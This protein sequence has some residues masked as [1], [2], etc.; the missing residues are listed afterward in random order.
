MSYME[1]LLLSKT[2]CFGFVGVRGVSKSWSAQYVLEV[3]SD[4]GW[5]PLL[6]DPKG[7]DEA[8]HLPAQDLQAEKLKTFGLEPKGFKTRYLTFRFPLGMENV[9]MN[10]ELE[11][12]SV[13]MLSF[14]HFRTLSGF[15]S[16]GEGREL[17]DAY[18]LAGGESASIED[19]ITALLRRK[20]PKASPRVLSLLISLFSDKSPFEPENLLEIVSKY[21]FTVIST[22]YF[23]PSARDLALFSLNIV[24]DNLASYL[25]QNIV[26][27][28]MIIHVRELREVAP[29]EGAMGSQWHLRE[30]IGNLVTFL[31]QA[32]TAVTR[33][34]FEVQN[35]KSIPKIILENSYGLFVHPFNFKDASQ[36]KELEKFFPIPESVIRS[37]AALE[38]VSHGTWIYISKDGHAEYV[39]IPPP[40]SLRIPEPADLDDATRLAGIYSQ[41]S[42]RRSLEKEAE[43][44]RMRYKYWI[45][46]AKVLRMEGK[47][48]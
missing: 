27:M 28:R 46:R 29:R 33:F 37:T 45:A 19:I 14:G 4:N 39:T 22:G 10:Y 34:S 21:D 23:K 1:D 8:I 32:K 20:G 43:E 48:E 41:Y 24:F 6:I 26:P 9:P 42:P 38:N 47:R 3:L 12:L 18:L 17:F 13:R 40:R 30:R 7:E 31:R 11:P 16:E 35:V 5:K 25:V 2:A 15:F 44:I 36:R